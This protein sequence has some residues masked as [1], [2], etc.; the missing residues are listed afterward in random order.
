MLSR[1]K[2]GATV[3][4]WYAKQTRAWRPLHGIV[5]TV[6]VVGSGPGPRNHGVR[7]GDQM[8]V[9]PAGNLRYPPETVR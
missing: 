5:G 1:P 3:Q 8:F 9:V 2:V 6:E 4:C 7:I